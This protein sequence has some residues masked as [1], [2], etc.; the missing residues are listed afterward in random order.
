M[1]TELHVSGRGRELLLA[2]HA[3]EIGA[4]LR[5]GDRFDLARMLSD[6]AR[7]ISYYVDAGLRTAANALP[8][9]LCRAS[10][11]G[12]PSLDEGVIEFAGEVILARDARPNASRPDP[13]GGGGFGHH[14]PADV[15]VHV[16]P[17]GDYAPELRRRGRARRSKTCW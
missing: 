13:A 1:R 9:R 7:T 2:Q 10:P 8:R 17:V 16:E 4:A 11:A 5:I 6:A 3:D 15:G 12:A 14:R